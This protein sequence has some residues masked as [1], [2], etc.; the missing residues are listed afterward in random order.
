MGL[1][2]LIEWMTGEQTRRIILE[3]E[4][5]PTCPKCGAPMSLEYFPRP[6]GRPGNM[7]VP[8]CDCD[9]KDGGQ[10]E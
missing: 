1:R 10:T 4:P 9:L 5:P 8:T 3:Q 7:Y 2:A 6:S